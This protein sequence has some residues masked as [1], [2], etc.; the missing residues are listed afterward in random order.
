MTTQLQS[1][2]ASALASLATFKGE[3]LSY[4]TAH[5]QSFTALTGFVIHPDRVAAPVYDEHGRVIAQKRSA[6]L[7]GPVSPL[8]AIGYEIKDSSPTTPVVW[9]VEG[10]KLDQQQIVTL[11]RQEVVGVYGPDRGA[12]A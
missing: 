9:A 12:S 11:S 5:G 2:M 6:Y 7:K 4:A 8:L 3:A 1:A 10:I